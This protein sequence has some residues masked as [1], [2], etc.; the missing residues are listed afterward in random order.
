L[1][2]GARPV[3]RDLERLRQ[4]PDV[5]WILD[6]ALRRLSANSRFKD[7]SAI[8]TSRRKAGS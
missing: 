3:R 8:P 5:G 7:S 2:E 4:D 1:G 6:T